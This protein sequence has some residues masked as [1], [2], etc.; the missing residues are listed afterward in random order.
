[1]NR[2]PG[3][4]ARGAA[5]APGREAGSRR[6]DESLRI[7]GV[8]KVYG[9]TVANDAMTLEIRSGE[10]HGLLG[11]NGAGK[12]TL[13][14]VLTGHVQ[15]DAGAV[16]ADGEPVDLASGEAALR[17]G[18]AA[19]Y[20]TP[21]LVGSM[22]GLENA[23]L[24]LGEPP[25][26]AVRRRLA[27]LA[28]D[29]GLPIELDVPVDRLDMAARLRIEFARALC[30]DPAVL[31]LDE[32]TTFLPPTQ[33]DEFL[34]CIRRLADSGM[35]VLMITH[36]LDEARR[37][38]D[39]VTVIRAGAVVADYAHQELPDND[40]I[41]M[42]MLGEAVSEPVATGTARDELALR[43]TGLASPAGD[44]AEMPLE[45]VDLDVRVGEI[46]GIAGVDGNGQI[47]LLEAVAG[48]RPNT[49]SVRLGDHD[50]SR[51][52]YVGRFRAG[53]QLLSGDRRRHGVVPELSVFEHFDFALD[54]PTR[55]EVLR[56]L[57][58][59]DTRPLSLDIAAT[60]LSGG[61]QQKVMLARALMA[62]PR[63]LLLAYPTQG[64]DVSAAARIH[65]ALLEYAREGLGVVVVSSD[66]DELL[67]LCDRVVVMYRGRIVGSQSRGEID[68]RALAQWFTGTAAHEEPELV[69][70]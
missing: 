29:L 38:C 3:T 56:C 39:R 7:E 10:I 66:L 60:A 43:V 54:D 22:T 36:R 16:L 48:A 23:A 65:A 55:E 35:A 46:V 5:P 9:T 51:Q 45:D 24:A 67:D 34:R 58:D 53:L 15:P 31:L 50:L 4:G 68:R 44:E 42:A 2:R 64:L 19:V 26:D 62:G 25:A 57:A 41:A 49:G 40:T 30:Q 8:T 11:Q 61:N 37:V 47:D 33:V 59:Y 69:A 20:Q 21:M 12:S 32:P 27:R 28:G 52:S 70:G 14:G 13:V 17:A 1:M 6:L 18:I 63:V